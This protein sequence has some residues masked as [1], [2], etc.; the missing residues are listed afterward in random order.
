MVYSQQQRKV[1]IKREEKPILAGGRA[2]KYL[3]CSH[4]RGL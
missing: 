2:K 4:L 1:S 3:E